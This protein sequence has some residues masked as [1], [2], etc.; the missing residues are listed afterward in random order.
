MEPAVDR[1]RL[2]AGL[3]RRI[4]NFG[5]ASFKGRLILQKTVY[6]LQAFGI[7]LGYQF[8]WYLRGPY[9]TRLTKEA[10]GLVDDFNRYG[11]VTFKSPPSE[12]RF[13][14]FLS[15]IEQ[16]KSDEIWLETAASA[17]FLVKVLG[18]TDRDQIFQKVEAKQPHVT[19]NLFEKCWDELT[20]AGLLP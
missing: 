8:S 5:I 13:Q 20:Q 17:H 7:Y 10:F 2:L 9:S 11:A 16:H 6:L 19:R 15:F 14:Q 18:H 12:E 3:L 1:A 4:G